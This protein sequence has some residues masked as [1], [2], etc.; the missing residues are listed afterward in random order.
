MDVNMHLFAIRMKLHLVVARFVVLLTTKDI[1]ELYDES[2]G[3]FDMNVNKYR[4]KNYDL[5]RN[6][7]CTS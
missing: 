5:Y 2:I 6:N 3:L 7:Y 1:I 4:V